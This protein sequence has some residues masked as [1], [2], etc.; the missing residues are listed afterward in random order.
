MRCLIIGGAGFIG[1]NVS[2][3]LAESG[4]AVTVLGRA[5]APLYQLS[6]KVSYISGDYKDVILLRRLLK[7][8]DELIDLAYATVPK[9]SF[10]DPVSDVLSNLP[11]GV[12]LIQEASTANLK[13]A[14]FV[15][16]GGTVYG[17]AQ[18]LP[19][20]E[21]HPTNPI[22]PYGITKL[23]LEKYILMFV[24]LTGLP[25]V[26]V[27]PGNAYGEYQLAFTGQGFIATAIKSILLRQPVNI[28]GPNGTIRDYVHVKDIARGIIAA[29]E[30]GIPGEVYNIGSGIG[31]NNIQVVKV[32]EPFARSHGYPV[33]IKVLPERGFDVSANILDSTKLRGISAWHPE[34]DFDKG[35]RRTW[36]VSLN[37]TDNSQNQKAN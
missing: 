25:A 24:A 23:A 15:S 26:V 4:R 2:N 28:F 14:V 30:F 3:M 35:I 10:D 12:G 7:E 31:L 5:S 9:S 32:I 8:T 1:S 21:E 36:Q 17:I 33:E 27:R 22:S 34:M 6:Q 19:I 29:L 18:N 11:A 37:E 13:K 16:S 20:R